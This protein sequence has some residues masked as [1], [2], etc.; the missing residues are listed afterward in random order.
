MEIDF[1]STGEVMATKPSI[2]PTYLM[3]E[4]KLRKSCEILTKTVKA[5]NLTEHP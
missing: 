1:I 5:T 2:I 3:N 4:Y